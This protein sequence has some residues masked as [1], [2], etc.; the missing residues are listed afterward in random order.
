MAQ[1]QPTRASPDQGLMI[2]QDTVVSIFVRKLQVYGIESTLRDFEA[3]DRTFSSL[4]GWKE[5]KESVEELFLAHR[6]QVLQDAVDREHEMTR[7]LQ[8]GI[9]ELRQML[10]D[11]RA[12]GDRQPS[13]SP[14][15]PSDGED[16]VVLPA[17]LATEKAT[18][19]WR[20]LQNVGFVD[21]HCQPT[22]LS[23][24]EAALL[25]YEMAKHLSIRDKWKTFE[26]FWQRNNMRGDYNDSMEQRKTLAFR[27]KLKSLF[28]DLQK[29]RH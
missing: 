27:D 4:P 19:M 14:D 15:E 6:K 12:N 22:G 29:D 1:Q 16:P 13:A 17:A 21:D 11:T 7:Q 23:R 10:H 26:A 3:L 20:K 25:A 18:A 8:Y 2:T 24:T 5:T 9:M 28:T